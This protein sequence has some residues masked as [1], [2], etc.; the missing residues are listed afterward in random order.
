MRSINKEDN[1]HDEEV[2]LKNRQSEQSL[3]QKVKPDIVRLRNFPRFSKSLCF[4]P[5]KFDGV[6][7]CP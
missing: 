5:M 1:G 7:K 4:D 2:L 6:W 3:R